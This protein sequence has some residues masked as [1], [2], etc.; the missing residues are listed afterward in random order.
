MV[1]GRPLYLQPEDVPFSSDKSYSDN[2]GRFCIL[3]YGVYCSIILL[4]IYAS[5][6]RW[7]VVETVIQFIWIF[8]NTAW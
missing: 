4:R 2:K 1:W 7:R 8:Q 3:V 6:I 5:R